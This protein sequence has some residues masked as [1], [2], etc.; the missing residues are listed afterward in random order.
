MHHHLMRLIHRASVAAAMGLAFVLS[1]ALP[2]PAS[3]QAAAR[4]SDKE[5]KSL[6]EQIYTDRDK[7][8]GNLDN[9]VKN[10]TIR[11]ASREISVEDALQDLQDNANK[12]KDRFNDD[13]AASAEVE[14]FQIGRAHV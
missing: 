4:L 5:V 12:M 13:Y 3:A 8:E 14:A 6:F 1:V 9:T 11:T 10:S 2:R 7:F